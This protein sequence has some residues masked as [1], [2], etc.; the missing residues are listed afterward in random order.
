MLLLF[1]QT[2]W[3]KFKGN[4]L[5]GEDI[6]RVP[7]KCFRSLLSVAY[8]AMELVVKSQLDGDKTSDQPQKRREKY[9][10]ELYS[11]FNDRT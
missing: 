1:K 8:R 6:P 9:I 2:A 7:V 11:H 3:E 10:T 5:L 4:N